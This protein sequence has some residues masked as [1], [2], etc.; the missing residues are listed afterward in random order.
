MNRAPGRSRES[1]S[2]DRLVEVRPEQTERKYKGDIS[3]AESRPGFRA[4]SYRLVGATRE[5][6]NWYRGGETGVAGE[7]CAN[8]MGLVL[9]LEAAIEETGLCP[10]SGYG[11]LVGR[12]IIFPVRADG[13][14]FKFQ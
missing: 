11:Q 2:R 8:L 6:W 10:G 3:G 13:A 5:V 4:A 1:A 7:F 9:D 14:V 12:C